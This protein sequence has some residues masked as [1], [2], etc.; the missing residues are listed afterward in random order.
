MN[1]K[2]FDAIVF[3]GRFQPFHKGHRTTLEKA[4]KLSKKVIVFIGSS[5]KPRDI[6]NPFTYTERKQVIQSTFPDEN[7]SFLP[8]EDETY[9]DDLWSDNVRQQVNSEVL[10]DS[11]IG[12][13]GEKKDHTSFYFDFFPE[14]DHVEGEKF[15][16]E[17]NATQIRNQ[18]FGEGVIDDKWL[19]SQTILF[20][21][22]F[23]RLEG[24]HGS[25]VSPTYKNLVREYE[26]VE[27]YKDLWKSN[28]TEIYGGPIHHTAD[29]I[30]LCKGHTL[31]VKRRAHPGKGTYAFPGGYVNNNERVLDSMLRELK[32]ETKID[33]PPGK[34]RGSIVDSKT[35]DDPERSV[36]GRVITNAY[37]IHLTDEVGLPKIKG[38]SDADKAVWVPLNKFYQM[39]GELFEDHYH[40]GKY[41]FRG[42]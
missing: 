8:I 22:K 1:S 9:N 29:A 7:I 20:L 14:W 42:R 28:G 3:I 23:K 40:I 6:R 38:S 34:L 19:D 15:I 2:E 18:Y 5:N 39:R 27:I 31:L 13:I 21:E 36:R 41:F 11:K 26:Y 25:I 17:I 32:E 33:V 37:F 4:L 10:V 16:S 24:S 35:F 30:V 12:I